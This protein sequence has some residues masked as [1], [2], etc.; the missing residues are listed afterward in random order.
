M[1]FFF[2][3]RALVISFLVPPQT[4]NF[5]KAFWTKAI[6]ILISRHAV[7][8]SLY[9]S[10]AN[11]TCLSVYFNVPF[12]S[13]GVTLLKVCTSNTSVP[14]CQCL[15]QQAQQVSQIG[16][17]HNSQTTLVSATW[18]V[19]ALISW[20]IALSSFDPAFPRTPSRCQRQ[21]GFLVWFCSFV[22][23]CV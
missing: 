14:V 19:I 15:W 3:V 20:S 13:A 23:L 6:I 1:K 11:I 16:M 22:Q 12:F 8:H 2:T 21:L 18:S 9:M 4:L 10:S 5:L 7:T 17:H